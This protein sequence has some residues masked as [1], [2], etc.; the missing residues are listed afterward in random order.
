M[1]NQFASRQEIRDKA[2]DIDFISFKRNFTRTR[3]GS[4]LALLGATG[5][6]AADFQAAATGV[7]DAAVISLFFSAH[8]ST[9][10][11]STMSSFY[12][13]RHSSE[14]QAISQIQAQ[15]NALAVR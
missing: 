7:A 8:F 4:V 1:E 2:T 11:Q 9:A 15:K 6:A 5:L 14:M 3:V 13:P 10:A 12:Q